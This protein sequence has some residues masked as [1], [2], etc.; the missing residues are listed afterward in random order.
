[1][2]EHAQQGWAMAAACIKHANAGAILVPKGQE[3]R[4]VDAST[5]ISLAGRD[6]EWNCQPF[7]LESLQAVVDRGLQT[8]EWFEGVTSELTDG[9]IDGALEC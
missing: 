1:M 2:R 9:L 6:D 8:Q 3:T 4:P 5:A 7:L